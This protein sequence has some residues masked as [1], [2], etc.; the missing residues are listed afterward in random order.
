MPATPYRMQ[1]CP[2]HK[3]GDDPVIHQRRDRVVVAGDDQCG[4]ADGPQPRQARPAEKRGHPVQG[5]Q[6]IRRPPDVHRAD[7]LRLGAQSPAEHGAGH[8]FQTFRTI[9]ARVDEVPESF[10][11]AGHGETAEGCRRQHQPA[12][13]AGVRERHL[14]C[15]RATERSAEHVGGLYAEFVEYLGAEAGQ[16]P[17]G[18]RE[19]R[20]LRPADA[21]R[22]EGDRAE[23]RQMGKQL[24][25]Q[26]HLAPDAGEEQQ[27]LAL[28]A[29]LSVDP[30]PPD[31]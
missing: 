3:R 27:R 22:V 14:L 8:P 28:S 5:G 11:A 25:P 20:H 30:Q 7:K 21:R 15:D 26:V 17:H 1:P 9:A 24:F 2:R 16:C 10:R 23:P 31:P 12:N 13:P 29:D 6:G 18:Q 4:M 19:G